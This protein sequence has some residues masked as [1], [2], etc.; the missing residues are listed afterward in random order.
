M[1]VWTAKRTA[2]ERNASYYKRAMVVVFYSGPLGE[3]GLGSD[4]CPPT[5]FLEIPS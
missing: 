2:T 3:H 1:R 4:L 5:G